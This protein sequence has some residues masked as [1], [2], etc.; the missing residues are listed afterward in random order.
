MQF[1]NVSGNFAEVFGHRAWSAAQKKRTVA[2]LRAA[3]FAAATSL[4]T[5][6]LVSLVSLVSPVSL[7]SLSPSRRGGGGTT[8]LKKY[9]MRF[10]GGH[11]LTALM[12]R[13]IAP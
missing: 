10:S 12:E 6:S 5:E 4:F 13:G 11:I 8:T 3:R 1:T 7:V 2:F 9:S